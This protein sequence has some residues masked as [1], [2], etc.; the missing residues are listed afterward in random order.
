MLCFL[1]FIKIFHILSCQ[2]KPNMNIENQM[3]LPVDQAATVAQT[4]NGEYISWKE[5]L[6]D[7]I[8]IGGVDI[9]GSDGLSVDDLDKDGFMDIVSVHESDTE[10]DGKP[11]G[12][13]RIAFGSNDPDVWELV[14]LADGP[15]AAAVE[16]AAIADI[17]GDGFLDIVA[18]C[19]LAH[20][21]YFENPGIKI[22]SSHW[23]RL[24][25][26]ITQNKGSYIRVFT[27]DLDKDGKQEII[28]AN[29]G[30]QLSDG[31]QS[32]DDVKEIV[33]PI[34]YFKINGNPMFQSS[35]K[36]HE[37]VSVVVPINSHPIDIDRDGDMDIIGGSRGERRILLIENILQDSIQFRIHNIDVLG[38]ALE[39]TFAK[40]SGPNHPWITGFNMV[41]EDIDRDGK[42]DIVLVEEKNYLI[43]LKQPTDWKSKW[44]LST[45]G[46]TAPDLIA[47]LSSADINND[48]HMDLMIGGYSRGERNKDGDVT[49]NHP[50][51]RLAW[52]ENPGNVNMKWKRH[53]ISRRKRGMYDKFVPQDMDGDG[54]IDFLSTRGNSQPYDGVF[55][56]EQVRTKSPVP[57]FNRAR[58]VDSEEMLLP[59]KISSIQE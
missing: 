41:F 38:S 2:P 22:R 13:I 30:D 28:A 14:T 56:L 47:G 48:G 4:K 57:N 46:E 53:D 44:I 17:N 54:D 50:L 21:I 25:P 31:T 24:I 40:E 36:E 33:K 39:G 26:A 49:R 1:L 37:I 16:D 6:I 7:D 11:R 55:W 27:A 23:Q 3:E 15:E 58:E 18:A 52:F 12:V 32:V 34:S 42:L 8:Q 19:E 59:E 29:K 43:W 51:G 5:H 10:Y 9:S 35:W 20:L 45:I